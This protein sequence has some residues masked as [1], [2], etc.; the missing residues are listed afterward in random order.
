MPRTRRQQC[1]N[2]LYHVIQRAAVNNLFESSEDKIAFLEILEQSKQKNNFSLFGFCLAVNQ[3]YHLLIG[4]N[5]ADLSKVMKEINIRFALYKQTKGIFRDRFVS[6]PLQRVDNIWTSRRDFQ[7]RRCHSTDPTYA[8]LCNTYHHLID[9]PEKY[10]PCEQ[11]VDVAAVQQYLNEEL[12]RLG[13]DLESFLADYELRNQWIRN[14][15]QT[16]P[17]SL[18]EIG[19]LVDLG[20]SSIS[21]ILNH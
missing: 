3:E 8:D 5:T 12:D 10:Q 15:R 9:D 21:K 17:L 14:I 13:L 4:T 19:A 1:D 18:K 20:E 6:I 16:S 11:L 7:Q 2:G